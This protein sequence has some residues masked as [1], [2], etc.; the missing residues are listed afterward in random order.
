MVTMRCL[1]AMVVLGD[2]VEVGCSGHGGIG[3]RQLLGR[4]RIRMK[5]YEFK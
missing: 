2:W 4:G 3:E 1:S 5:Y